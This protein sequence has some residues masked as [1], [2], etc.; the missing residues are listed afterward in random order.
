MPRITQRVF[1]GYRSSAIVCVPQLLTEV[2]GWE[3]GTGM[4]GRA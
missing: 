2:L 4:V 1:D 3:L